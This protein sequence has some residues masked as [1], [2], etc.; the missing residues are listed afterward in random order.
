[1]RY[2]AGL[3]E[4]CGPAPT[5]PVRRPGVSDAK[6]HNFEKKKS[7]VNRLVFLCSWKKYIH[8]TMEKNALNICAQNSSLT[9][10]FVLHVNGF[11]MLV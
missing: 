9:L 1:M 10:L 5:Q 4:L 2:Y 3:T 11:A 7:V 8:C 6:L